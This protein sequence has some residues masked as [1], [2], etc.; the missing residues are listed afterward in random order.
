MEARRRLGEFLKTRRSHLRPE[1]VG[2]AT[3]GERRRVP[4]LRREELAQLAGVS[5][6]YYSRLEQ[7]QSA[8]ASPEVLDALAGA[9]RLDDTERRHLHELAAGARRPA[10]RRRPAP[11]RVTPA[12]RQLLATLGDVPVVVLGRF[13]DVLAWNAA[14]HALFAGH[15]APD[16]PERPGTRPNM[17]RLVFLDPHTR[18][19]YADWPAKARAVVATLRMASGRHPD[20]PRPAALV[21]ELSVRSTEFAAWWADQRVKAGGDAVYEMHHPLVGA[22]TVTH[23]ALL[24]EQEQHVVVAT[25]EPGSPSHAAMTLLTHTTATARRTLP[26]R[27]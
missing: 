18:E 20:D 12:L 6:P 24:T 1:D 21:G 8:N 27:G 7:G 3:Y 26:T 17:A 23:Q 5:A 19:L 16:A 11:E 15:L 14:G 2:L 9:L 4:G 13:S 25:T 22:L 10:P